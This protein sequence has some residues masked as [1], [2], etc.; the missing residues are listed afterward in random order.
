MKKIER[1]FI[2]FL[3]VLL[4]SL[5]YA[6]DQEKSVLKSLEKIKGTLE[7]GATDKEFDSLFTDANVEINILKRTCKNEC[8]L[9]A[10]ENCYSSYKKAIEQKKSIRDG[11]RLSSEYRILSLKYQKMQLQYNTRQFEGQ[12]REFEEK[13]TSI[14]RD[15]ATAEQEFPSTI[16][17]AQSQLDSA[18]E[19]LSQ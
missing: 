17:Q 15:K 3:I 19:C 4:S 18:Y 13:S 14:L 2:L 6:G 8:F 10:V 7:T 12:I 11:D 1:I 5:S 16:K 9:M